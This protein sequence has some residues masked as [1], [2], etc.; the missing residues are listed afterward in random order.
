MWHL[1][2]S[3]SHI[4]SLSRSY[5][6]LNKP[7][8]Q[9]SRLR[10]E[11]VLFYAV[12]GESFPRLAFA[13]CDVVSSLRCA[14][15]SWPNSQTFL[16]NI[17]ISLST[18][19]PIY[20]AADKECHLLAVSTVPSLGLGPKSSRSAL[21]CVLRFYRVASPRFLT[22]SFLLTLAQWWGHLHVA[23]MHPLQVQAGETNWNNEIAD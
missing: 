19:F 6:S 15:D 1:N 2:I 8:L 10:C 11:D 17:L 13:S 23:A 21:G 5:T 22:I 4:Y 20:V 12:R 18:Y 16:A 9:I 3:T 7:S 14:N